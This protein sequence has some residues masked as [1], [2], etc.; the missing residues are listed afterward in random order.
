NSGAKNIGSHEFCVIA[1]FN[2]PGQHFSNVACHVKPDEH[3]NWILSGSPPDFV[4][5]QCEAICIN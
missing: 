1:G 2:L 4:H 5:F 3:K